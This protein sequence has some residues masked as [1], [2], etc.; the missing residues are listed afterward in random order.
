MVSQTKL[1]SSCHTS[2]LLCQLGRH[3][4][5]KLVETSKTQI[6][7]WYQHCGY[8][9]VVAAFRMEILHEESNSD[10][11]GDGNTTVAHIN[12]RPVK[13]HWEVLLDPSAKTQFSLLFAP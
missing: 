6:S 7:P 3:F 10:S 9:S 11:A 1:A 2:A 5:K 13:T 12:A 8:D 4:S